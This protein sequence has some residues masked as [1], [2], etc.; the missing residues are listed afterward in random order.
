MSG[1]VEVL[2]ACMNQ[3][4]DGLYEKMN[5]QSI[6]V[7]A[8]Q[9]DEYSYKVYTREDKTVKLVS[10][11]DRGVGKN[12][13]VALLN[14]T[15]DYLIIA[16]EDMVYRDDYVRT[17]LKAFDKKPKADII[18][19]ELNYLNG[20]TCGYKPNKKMKQV[21][22]Y[23]S[24]RYGAARI[25]IKKK[26][27]LKS[28]IWFSLL[29]G[30]GAPYSCGEDSLF[31]CEAL[32]KGLKIYSSPHIIADV[33]QGESSWFKGY[34][35]KYFTD[36]GLWIAN[37]FPVLKYP[38]GLYYVWRLRH[39]TKEFSIFKIAGMIFKGIKTFKELRKEE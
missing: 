34:T 31:I 2:V 12:R 19:F 29:Y 17:V 32:R 5:L 33:K 35:E 20:F 21:H 23:N 24:L 22:L 38:I 25:T 15:G 18:V 10:T 30:G 39:T 1:N 8:N 14:A 13:N 6:A 16:D 36:R 27:L 37:A 9:C 3:I 26:S 28:N 4:D 11:K 7:L